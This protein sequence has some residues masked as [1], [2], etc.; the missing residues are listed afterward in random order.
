MTHGSLLRT[1]LGPERGFYWLAI[2][3]GVAMS[4]LSLAVPLSVQ[5]LIGSIA[6]TAM[7]RPLVVLGIILFALLSL[8]GLL[9]T[10]QTWTMDRFG[11]HFFARI[12][13]EIILRNLH[14][15]FAAV[16]GVNR[17]ELANRFFEIVTVQ[18]NVPNLMVGGSTL[19]LQA[20]VGFVVVS[21]YH[22]VFVAF[23]GCILL[24]VWCIW[25]IWSRRSTESKIKE[26]K[27]KYNVARWL[28]EV[29]RAND[30]F[31]SERSLNFAVRRSEAVI[32]AYLEAHRKHFGHKAGQLIACLALYA[33]ASAALLV[34][35]G[36]LVISSSLALGQLVAAELILASIFMAI[37][38]LPHY[39]SQWYELRASLDKLAE[40]Y[41]I[42][43]E[44]P[45]AGERPAEGPMEITFRNVTVP[46][47]SGTMRFDF[48]LPAGQQVMIA[49]ASHRYQKA[50]VD[51]LLRHEEPSAGSIML[52]RQNLSDIHPHA[53]RDTVM[54]VDNAMT[55]ECSI[56]D[57]LALGNTRLTRAELRAAL[58]L[59]SLDD[60]VEQLP[61]GLDTPLGPL[62]HP[63][64]RGEVIRLKI[65]AAILAKP[66][67]L[68]LT[69]VFDTLALWQRRTI[70]AALYAQEGFVLDF[71][72]RRDIEDYDRYLL[73]NAHGQRVFDSLSALV[74]AEQAPGNSAASAELRLPT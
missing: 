47:R 40:F 12:S 9:Y 26:S 11:R 59:V 36:G 34:V 37:A 16:E 51:L 6:N 1:L 38:Q 70:L 73:V 33:I 64:S 39:L 50:I 69:E 2:I 52:G 61:K 4:V 44:A 66:R 54:V 14:A 31:K 17:E 18:K 30:S 29:A 68:L 32:A 22:P 63:L 13:E 25:M 67:V 15:R 72:T 58:S 27:A 42:P 55:M 10:L 5:I 71:S 65:A 35:G 43:L 41:A 20:L 28:E 60:V 45:V 62:G 21:A 7:M 56:A 23:N 3:H 46:Y 49:C 48:S 74:T 8:Y 53:L 57:N 19:L 24:A